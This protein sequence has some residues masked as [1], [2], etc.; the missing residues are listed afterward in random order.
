[1]KKQQFKF[2]FAV[3][4]FVLLFGVQVFAQSDWLDQN[5]LP[6]WNERKR[7]NQKIDNVRNEFAV[8][9]NRQAFFRDFLGGQAGY[10][11]TAHID[12]FVLE[13]KSAAAD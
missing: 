2:L 13:I 1:M 8:T 12:S 9:K 11:L 10:V 4:V 6:S 5:P 7:D 3:S